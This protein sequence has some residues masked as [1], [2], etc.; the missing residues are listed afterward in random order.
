MLK[1][2]GMAPGGSGEEAGHWDRRPRA[3]LTLSHGCA[4]GMQSELFLALWKSKSIKS[5]YFRFS[6]SPLFLFLTKQTASFS[7]R[8]FQQPS[9]CGVISSLSLLA[10]SR[11]YFTLKNNY[12]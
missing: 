3:V 9:A 8:K 4:G 2:F 7:E 10:E 5:K 12:F 6:L 1:T 11:S